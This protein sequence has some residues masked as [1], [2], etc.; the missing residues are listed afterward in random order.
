MQT[1][2]GLKFYRQEVPAST[3]DKGTSSELLNEDVVEEKVKARKKIAKLIVGGNIKVGKSVYREHLVK[4]AKLVEVRNFLSK[5]EPMCC[6][7]REGLCRE[8]QL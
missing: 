6:L 7:H 3:S 5:A 4:E 8:G 2:D 1:E